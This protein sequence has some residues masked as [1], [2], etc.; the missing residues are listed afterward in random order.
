MKLPA[1]VAALVAL[2]A[3]ALRCA[4]PPPPVIVEPAP[5][6]PS[7]TPTATATAAAAP[8]PQE[9][10]DPAADQDKLALV[11]SICPAAIQH[12][13]GKVRV[14]CRTCPPFEGDEAKPDGR[15][16][17]DPEQLFPVEALYRGSFSRPGADEIAAVFEGCEPHAGNYGGTLFAEK[18]SDGYRVITYASGLHPASCQTYRRKDR[19]DV[20]V[21]QWSDAHQSTA[22][23]QVLV[24][25]LARA[26][27]DDPL[28]GWEKL[29]HVETNGYS[30]CWG[31]SPEVGVEQ[32]KV[33]GFRFED[34]NGDGVPDVVVEVLHKK[35]PYSAAIDKAIQ[36]KCA[37]ASARKPD[38]MPSIDVAALLGKPAKL[39]LE[40]LADGAGFK[41]TPK[42]AALLQHM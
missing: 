32:G 15:V 8:P 35:T 16:A 18:T 1:T 2:A 9:P 13:E 28:K 31:V 12:R 27:A 36:R 20:L 26:T 3:L 14:G 29:A 6:P 38:D 42:T 30:V 33:L 37:E 22:F 41:P 19:R 21:C 40:F 10:I 4:P 11:T 23:T 7:A 39:T 34:R 5:P 25:D 17:I 24:Y